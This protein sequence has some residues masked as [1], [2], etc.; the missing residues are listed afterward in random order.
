M[1]GRRSC[2]RDTGSVHP[3]IAP[4]GVGE[5]ASRAS[6]GW[7]HGSAHVFYAAGKQMQA[8]GREHLATFRS[9]CTPG[10]THRGPYHSQ[11][12]IAIHWPQ[13]LISARARTD[14]RR[15]CSR[16]GVGLVD[17]RL[18]ATDGLAQLPVAPLRVDARD[19]QLAVPQVARRGFQVVGLRVQPRARRMP[20]RVRWRRRVPPACAAWP[21][22][23]SRPPPRPR[24]SS[25]RSRACPGPASRR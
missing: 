7:W 25:R 22:A 23:C 6:Q 5:S 20:A 15:A 10:R 8:L 14:R 13:A 9:D 21:S 17:C 2:R 3:S 11:A 16:Y 12:C 19:L 24:R 4:L 18:P 1:P